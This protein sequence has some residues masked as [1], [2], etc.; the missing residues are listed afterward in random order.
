VQFVLRPRHLTGL[1]VIARKATRIYRVKKF[2]ARHKAGM[3]ATTATIL[4][5]IGGIIGTAWQAQIA[6]KERARA[7]RR[8][9]DVR[10]LANSF[11]FDFH[12]AI[13]K[14]S[15]STAAQQL[16]VEKA[17]EYLNSLARESGDD[18]S[19]QM[20]LAA[21]YNKIAFIQDN[22]YY[23]G[24]GNTSGAL[25]SHKKAL[26]LYQIAVTQE[27]ENAGVFNEMA[28]SYIGIG[29]MLIKLGDIAEAMKQYRQSLEIRQELVDEN[30]NN[31]LFRRDLAVSYQRVGDTAG[32][33]ILCTG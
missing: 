16:I 3:I 10:E 21:A 4:A 31:S 18:L 7:E 25:E 15:G 2:I 1:P 23:G 8:F 33:P 26:E 6:E 28:R 20:E 5:L 22:R 24:L 11:L 17:L 9:N 27:P 14:L 12:K 13:E 32:N 30:P 29:D 19:L